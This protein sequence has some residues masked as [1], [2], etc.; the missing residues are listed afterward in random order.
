M[1]EEEMASEIKEFITKKFTPNK[2]Y[3]FI[4]Y[5]HK[6]RKQVMQK[7]LSWVREGQ[8]LTMNLDFE[9]PF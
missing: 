3:I 2:Q 1:S 5:S 8:N 4:S 7:V 6:D 9:N